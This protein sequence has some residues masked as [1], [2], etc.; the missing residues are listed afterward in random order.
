MV[1]TPDRPGTVREATRFLA[2]SLALP[3]WDPGG[4]IIIVDDIQPD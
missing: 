4:I 1:R 3:R 2:S